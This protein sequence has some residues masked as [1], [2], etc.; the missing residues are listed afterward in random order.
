MIKFDEF[1]DLIKDAMNVRSTCE[2]I[3]LLFNI[4]DVDRTGYITS[5]ELAVVSQA[6]GISLNKS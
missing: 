3:Q 6:I 4:F 5:D 1:L 2:D